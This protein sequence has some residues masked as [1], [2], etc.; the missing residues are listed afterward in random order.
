MDAPDSDEPPEH[1]LGIWLIT[2]MMDEV[3][4]QALPNV[5]QWQLTKSFPFC[6][7]RSQ[8]ADETTTDLYVGSA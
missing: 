3:V 5:N 2:R 8:P 6:G 1:G 7:G 4:Y